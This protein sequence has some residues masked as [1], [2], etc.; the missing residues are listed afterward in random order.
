MTDALL[1]CVTNGGTSQMAAGLLR[2]LVADDAEPGRWQVGS[3]GTRAGT[4]LHALSVA[5]LADVGVDITDQEP[6][7][8]TPELPE[9]ADL[10]VTVGEAEVEH[11][12]R[13][14]HEVGQIDQPSLRGVDGPEHMALVRD[15]VARH[16]DELHQRLT[17]AR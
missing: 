7:Q 14:R 16:V 1:V 17:A 13:L 4:T 6:R 8:L 2:A 5:S 15:D 3:A 11:L 12:Q 10:V 9:S